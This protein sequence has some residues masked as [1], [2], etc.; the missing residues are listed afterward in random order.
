MPGATVTV[1]GPD[2]PVTERSVTVTGAGENWLEEDFAVTSVPVEPSEQPVGGTVTHAEGVPVPD[3]EVTVTDADGETVDTATTNDDGAW[4]INLPPGSYTAVVHPG[5]GYV[6]DGEDTI[7]FEVADVEVTGLDVVL[8][9]ATQASSPTPSPGPD[10]SAGPEPGQGG[11]AATGAT[12]GSVALVA[13]ILVALGVALVR[14][15]RQKTAAAVA[16]T[17][18]GSGR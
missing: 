6:V 18:G 3:T 12:V 1:S 15:S 8:G 7:A 17:D 13:G 9:T 4:G 11:L 10:P 5:E 14:V 16:D 2:G